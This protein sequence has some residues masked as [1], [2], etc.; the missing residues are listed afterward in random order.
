LLRAFFKGVPCA[1]DEAEN[2]RQAVDMVAARRYDLILMDIRMPVM[3]GYA[4]VRQIRT[5]EQQLGVFPVPIIA[6]T[7]SGLEEEVR[8]CLASGCNFYVSKPISKA[9][10]LGAVSRATAGSHVEA[11]AAEN[12]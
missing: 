10:L 9:A 12:N 1:L 11:T 5:S 3:D 8:E 2:G 4:A 6:L 7:A